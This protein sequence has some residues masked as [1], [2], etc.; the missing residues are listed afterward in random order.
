MQP[1]L[2]GPQQQAER[3]TGGKHIFNPAGLAIVV[4]LFAFSTVLSGRAPKS[5]QAKLH[6]SKVASATIW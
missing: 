2:V 4:L 3:Q 1:R 5:R 6:T